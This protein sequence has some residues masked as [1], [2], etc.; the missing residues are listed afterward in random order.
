MTKTELCFTWIK[1]TKKKKKNFEKKIQKL[2]DELNKKY[3]ST[4]HNILLFVIKIFESCPIFA[5]WN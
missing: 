3:L 2:K 4:Q 5:I 1:L